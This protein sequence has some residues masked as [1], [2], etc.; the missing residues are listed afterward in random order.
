MGDQECALGSFKPPNNKYSGYW[1]YL[2]SREILE[3]AS[4][5]FTLRKA[6]NWYVSR[7]SKICLQIMC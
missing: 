3:I 4:F 2:D 7:R 1:L 6:W 5:L